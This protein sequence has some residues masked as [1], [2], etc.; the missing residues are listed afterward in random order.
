M[1]LGSEDAA[2]GR[3]IWVTV[4]RIA[5]FPVRQILPVGARLLPGPLSES[6]QEDGNTSSALQCKPSLCSALTLLQPAHSASCPYCSVRTFL[7][8]SVL[9]G[10]TRQVLM[11]GGNSH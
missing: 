6:T 1:D 9:S 3:A 4:G 7:C 8:S 2:D 11:F 10:F 5:Y